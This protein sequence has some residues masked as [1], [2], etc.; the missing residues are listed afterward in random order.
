MSK[1]VEEIAAEILAAALAGKFLVPDS[2]V[3]SNQA[4]QIASA[5]KTILEAVKK[6]SEKT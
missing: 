2:N 5:Y 6:G 4:R 3:T 1:S